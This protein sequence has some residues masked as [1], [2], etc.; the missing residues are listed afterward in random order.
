MSFYSHKEEMGI[1]RGHRCIF[2]IQAAVLSSSSNTELNCNFLETTI[3]SL[4]AFILE[5]LF[6]GGL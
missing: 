1:D 4:S 5:R 3:S 6:L 2:E